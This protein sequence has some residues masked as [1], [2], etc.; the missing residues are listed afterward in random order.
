V[1]APCKAEHLFC[2]ALPDGIAL[3]PFGCKPPEQLGCLDD[4]EVLARID[5]LERPTVYLDLGPVEY[6]DVYANACIARTY[7]RVHNR[8]GRLVLCNVRPIAGE[9]FRAA[10][11]DHL[12]V[13]AED[14]PGRRLPDPAWLSWN[15]G[16]VLALAR[17]IAEGQ[18]FGL[19]P[20]LGDALEEAGCS[21]PDVLEH[22]RG[23]TQH[24][25]A[26]WV[27]RLLL[28][29]RQAGTSSTA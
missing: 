10:R 25:P 14:V 22:C 9:V 2:E 3:Y 23:R 7:R 29:D 21:L 20:V 18:D 19:L 13:R 11:L 17:A 8:D 15:G 12:D 1:A 4:E 28:G 16:A 26:C 27:I 5:A 24:V 6:L